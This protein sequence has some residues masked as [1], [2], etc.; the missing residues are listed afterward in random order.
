MKNRKGFGKINI[1]GNKFL[2]NWADNPDGPMLVMYDENDRKIEIPYGIW[3]RYPDSEEY[4][5]GLPVLFGKYKVSTWH[6]KHKKGPEW[7]GWGKREAR[8]MYFKYKRY[9]SSAVVCA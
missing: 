2:F 4:T 5:N 1:N 8:E 6:G 3:H 7:G 9:T